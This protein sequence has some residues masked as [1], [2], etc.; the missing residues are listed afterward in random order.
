M[1]QMN[2]CSFCLVCLP[3]QMNLHVL[4]GP[5][6]VFVETQPFPVYTFVLTSWG[7]L[8]NPMNWNPEITQH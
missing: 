3:L 2:G 8:R 5:A 7:L 6:G 1:S 4:Q